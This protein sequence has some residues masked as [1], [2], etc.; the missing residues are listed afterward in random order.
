MAAS[1]SDLPKVTA[2]NQWGQTFTIEGDWGC[3]EMKAKDMLDWL[4]KIG[5]NEVVKARDKTD[6]V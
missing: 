1:R 4:A 6:D 3:P 2:R 5:F